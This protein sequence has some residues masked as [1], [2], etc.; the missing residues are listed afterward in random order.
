MGATKETNPKDA[1]GSTKA[2]CGYFPDTALLGGELAFLEGALKYGRYN[3][4]VAGVRAW[5]YNE[6]LERHRKAW[7]NGEDIDPKSNLPHLFKMLACVAV[8]IDAEACDKLIDD[9]P[10]RAP[11]SQLLEEAEQYAQ[12]LRE[13]LAGFSPKQYTIEDSP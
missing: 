4:R 12:E 3:W 9:R 11:L 2:P 13:K 5:I 8:L 7:W 1:V 10:P 6:A